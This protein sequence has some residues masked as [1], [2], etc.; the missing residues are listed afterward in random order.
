MYE[1]GI[2]TRQIPNM[3]IFILYNSYIMHILCFLLSSKI[4]ATLH[5]KWDLVPQPKD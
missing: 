5:G 2:K 1:Y 4:L 3:C